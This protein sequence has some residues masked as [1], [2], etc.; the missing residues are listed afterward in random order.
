MKNID[1][2]SFVDYGPVVLRMAGMAEAGAANQELFVITRFNALAGKQQL[3]Y[4]TVGKRESA[5]KID[6]AAVVGRKWCTF[7]AAS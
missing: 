1:I 2:I 6:P 7:L 3:R 4:L 5:A